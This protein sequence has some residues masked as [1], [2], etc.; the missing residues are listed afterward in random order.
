M[1]GGKKEGSAGGRGQN[2]NRGGFRTDSA[3]SNNRFGQ[4]RVLQPWVPDAND[5]VDGS[6][7]RSSGSGAGG[8]SGG[9]WDQFAENEKL[10]GLKSDYNENY[11]TTSINTNDPRYN[12]RMSAADRKARE[13]ERSEATTTHVAEERQMDFTASGKD[14]AGEN[15]EDKYSGVRRQQDFPPLGAGRENRYVAPAKRA[16]TSQST[17]KGAPVDPAIISSQI[18]APAK[19]QPTPTPEESKARASPAATNGTSP[20]PNATPASAGTPGPESIPATI[21]T[22]R[23][24]DGTKTEKLSMPAQGPTSSV[25][26]RTLS[27]QAQEGVASATSTVERDVL[28]HFK[29]FANQQRE[30]AKQVRSSKAKADKEVKLTELKKF[31]ST[32]KLSTPVPTDLVSIIAKDP[33]KQIE[34]QAKAIKN[35]EEVAR[36]KSKDVSSKPKTVTG[37]EGPAKAGEQD[38]PR[39]GADSRPPKGPHATQ[40]GSQGNSANRHAGPRQSFQ[41][42]QYSQYRNNRPQQ[43]GAQQPQPG[44]LAQRLRNADSQNPGKFGMPPGTAPLQDGRMPP[45]GPAGGSDP[46]VNR[47]LS[48]VPSHMGAKLNPNSSEFRPNAFAPT[49]NPGQSTASSPRPATNPASDSTNGSAQPMGTPGSTGTPL[50][51]GPPPIR[52]KTKN[53]SCQ[54]CNILSTIKAI[55]PPPGRKWDDNGGLRPSYDT[56]PTWRQFQDDESPESTMHLTVKELFERQ[57]FGGSSMATPNPS[58]VAPHL[59]HQHQLPF[60]LQQGSHNMGPRQSPHLPHMQMHGPQHGPGPYQQFGHDDHRMVHSNSAQS[61]ASPRMPP[62]SMAYP[63]MNSPAQIPSSQSAYMGPGTPQM[64]QY[65]NFSNQY[66]PQHGQMGGPMMMQPHFMPGAQ[67][68]VG[69]PQMMYPGGNPQFMPHGGPPQQGPGATGYPSPGRPVAPM[70]AHQGSQQGQPM[71]GMS[72]SVQYSQPSFGPGHH[73]Q[74]QPQQ[75]AGPSHVA[76]SKLQRRRRVPV[77]WDQ[78]PSASF[79][80]GPSAAEREPQL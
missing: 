69:N 42:Q 80:S 45:T 5:A 35:A 31:A 18:K 54:K 51:M 11:Y 7:E 49:F 33:T 29:N 74:Q 20:G 73:Q 12:E 64:N 9:A 30:T 4:E 59:P 57:P 16:P 14:D 77:F 76:S 66:M 67:G 10:F 52:R 40:M 60:H 55:E 79:T 19:K 23:S 39:T 3:I 32:F 8:S 15:E 56:P 26:G 71:Y 21:G 70:M 38:V 48:G 58:H 6:L 34:I 46:N 25:N 36:T 50:G 43:M 78:P 2:G 53:V 22:S 68:M 47:R 41:Q 62:A 28:H 72:P 44:S 24:T 37:K 13:I 63:A 65:R 1:P 17:V 61:F 27:P 75:P